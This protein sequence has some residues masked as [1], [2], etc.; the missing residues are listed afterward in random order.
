MRTKTQLRTR[1]ALTDEGGKRGRNWDECWADT[2]CES[3]RHPRQPRRTVTIIPR[4]TP[5]S[6]IFEPDA[7][8]NFAHFPNRIREMLIAIMPELPD[9]AENQRGNGPKPAK[10]NRA[11]RAA[12]RLSVKEQRLSGNTPRIVVRHAVDVRSDRLG[13]ELMLATGRQ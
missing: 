2:Q 13:H 5:L 6:V 7:P 12:D 9:V 4:A 3:V 11:W 8:L 10:S 1:G